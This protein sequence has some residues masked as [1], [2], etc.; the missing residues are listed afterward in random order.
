MTPDIARH[1]QDI[2]ESE[3]VPPTF[4]NVEITET[5]AVSSEE[6]LIRNIRQLQQAGFSLSMDD[7]GT[8]YSNIAQINQIRYELIKLDK[9]MIWPAFDETKNQKDRTMAK[10]L[11]LSA[12]RML[13]SMDVK[14]VAEGVETRE[15]VDF[16]TRQ[17][18]DYLQGYY[19]S[20]PVEK[21]KFI[22]FIQ[23]QNTKKGTEKSGEETE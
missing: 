4:I 8:G 13:Q 7:F 10:K 19:F 2:L 6:V 20:R 15:M 1:L 23:E 17:G 18:V 22:E 3:N 14:I 21:S 11:L 9:S 16:L 12:I 5:A